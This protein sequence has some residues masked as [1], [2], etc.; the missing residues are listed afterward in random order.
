M[1]IKNEKGLAALRA[2]STGGS[3][4]LDAYK[5]AQAS[6]AASRTS[7][8][9]GSLGS[10]DVGEAVKSAQAKYAPQVA[11]GDMGIS[12]LNVAADSYL[13]QAAN[14]LSAQ[15]Y[16]DQQNLTFQAAKLKAKQNEMTE[17]ER[18]NQLTGAADAWAAQQTGNVQADAALG[19]Q[20]GNL[21]TRKAN[22]RA[23]LT[24]YDQAQNAPGPVQGPTAP[25]QGPSLAG[26]GVPLEQQGP[27]SAMSGPSAFGPLGV[28]SPVPQG[29]TRE[30]ILGQ[31]A[32]LDQQY[33]T[34]A[35]QY[36]KFLG[37]DAK[38]LLG[39]YA[40]ADKG[41]TDTVKGLVD[42]LN[43]TARTSQG[44]RER[45][46]ARGTQGRLRDLAPAFGIDP[47][48]AAGMFREGEGNDLARQNK[49][50]QEEAYVAGDSKAQQAAVD[51]ENAGQFGFASGADFNSFKKAADLPDQEIQETLASPGWDALGQLTDSFISGQEEF[52]IPGIGKKV[53]LEGR[54][55]REGLTEAIK[56]MVN[57]PSLVGP[58]GKPLDT[59]AKSKLIQLASRY[60]GSK[61][62]GVEGKGEG[63]E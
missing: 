51:E 10:L 6:E 50:A 27:P 12:N 37:A 42:F 35:E 8:L 29:M 2:L 41:N 21:A 40:D 30:D 32:G 24:A 17:E 19:G 43:P 46:I 22:L 55:G 60:Y 14:K 63:T 62:F 5:A 28:G 54:E 52:E 57:D 7:A 49:I 56:E 4:G 20:L 1:P 26:A 34:A 45:D 15:S 36:A 44:T 48:T 38:G 9:Q 59:A 58:D 16:E 47:L 33:A 23:Q 11:G 13:S 31:M 25:M 3:A 53:L 39:A 61:A 18:M